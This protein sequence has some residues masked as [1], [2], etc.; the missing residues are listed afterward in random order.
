MLPH[1]RHPSRS[2]Q[3]YTDIQTCTIPAILRSSAV[4]QGAALSATGS[5]GRRMNTSAPA[6]SSASCPTRRS[7]WWAAC[8]RG[9]E[10]CERRHSGIMSSSRARPGTSARHQRQRESL[11]TAAVPLLPAQQHTGHISIIFKSRTLVPW[12]NVCSSTLGSCHVP[13][14][15]DSF[16]WAC[17]RVTLEEQENAA[18][19][20][21]KSSV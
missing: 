14:Q 20:A 18:E 21:V 10:K 12:D 8:V 11:T 17:L 6:P 1:S 13:Q 5:G 15:T 7:W 2:S 9:V 3:Q 4:T 16:Q 19:G